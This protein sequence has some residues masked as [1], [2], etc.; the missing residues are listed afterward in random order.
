MNLKTLIL[1][2]LG[3]TIFYQNSLSQTLNYQEKVYVFVNS[4]TLITGEKLL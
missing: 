1:I 3:A 4:N 2:A